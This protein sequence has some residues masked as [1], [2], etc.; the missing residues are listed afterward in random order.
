MN[1]KKISLS[2][3]IPLTFL[4]FLTL[5]KE[6][7]LPL[8]ANCAFCKRF[9]LDA[10]KFYEDDFVIALLNYKPVLKLDWQLIRPKHRL[11]QL[12]YF[13]ILLALGEE[14]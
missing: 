2:C 12:I 9:V 11:Q 13:A 5:N 7:N 14:S 6:P 10:Q 1:L 8:R 3:L 4:L